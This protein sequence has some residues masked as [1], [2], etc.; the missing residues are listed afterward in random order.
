[1]S[2]KY[3]WIKKSDITFGRSKKKKK[4]AAKKEVVILKPQPKR[5]SRLARMEG[6][7]NFMPKNRVMKF[8]YTTQHTLTSAVGVL[9]NRQYRA[10]GCHDPDITGI[11][12]QP[13]GWDQITA[14]YNHYVVLGS[15]ITVQFTPQTDNV[16]NAGVIGLYL[17]DDTT[18]GFTS[19]TT[20]IEAQK[21]GWRII[22]GGSSEP[23]SISC[24]FSAKEFFNVKDVKDNVARL[25]SSVTTS[26][27][28]EAVYNLFYQAA[29]ESSTATNL[30][31]VV[32]I[33]YIVAFSEPKDIPAS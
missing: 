4:R 6:I 3:D 26:T 5:S 13:Y 31:V 9:T 32:M 20:F 17:S 15:K 12:H 14:F 29:D 23:K 21:G 25:G 8:R 33:D 24:K 1:M 28:E 10:N 16:A 11:G 2:G 18:H 19:Y 27:S 7:P 22:N 30:N